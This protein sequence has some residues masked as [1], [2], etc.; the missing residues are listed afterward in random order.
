MGSIATA[1]GGNGQ[2]G[3]AGRIRVSQ[4]SP[5]AGAYGTVDELVSTL[6]FA[7]SLCNEPVVARLSMRRGAVIL[8]FP[9]VTPG[10]TAPAFAQGAM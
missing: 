6:G 2:T 3:V 5:R 1:R 9:V 8:A 7:R 10:G 4:A